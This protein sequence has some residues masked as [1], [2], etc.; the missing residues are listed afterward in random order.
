MPAYIRPSRSFS[1]SQAEIN[2][3][4]APSRDGLVPFKVGYL[5]RVP[6]MHQNF[7]PRRP[8]DRLSSLIFSTTLLMRIYITGNATA[9]V[10]AFGVPDKVKDLIGDPNKRRIMATEF[11]NGMAHCGTLDLFQNELPSIDEIWDRCEYV[12]KRQNMN[13]E[14]PANPPKFQRSNSYFVYLISYRETTPARDA[15]ALY[16]GRSNRPSLGRKVI[17]SGA[18]HR[19]FP[20]SKGVKDHSVM[21]VWAKIMLVAMFESFNPYML[22]IDSNYEPT[23]HV[24]D[25]P[26]DLNSSPQ[27]DAFQRAYSAPLTNRILEITIKV[28]IQPNFQSFRLRDQAFSYKIVHSLCT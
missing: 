2:N 24:P 18:L 9:A 28:K 12:R 27:R 22:R 16:S 17:A 21:W 3:L 6:R 8:Q 11:M 15:N 13:V 26:A 5:G 10:T 20:I 14:D 7:D 1:L 19:M 25:A 23:Y 4:D